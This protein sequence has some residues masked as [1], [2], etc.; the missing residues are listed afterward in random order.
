MLN[1]AILSR[2]TE[3]LEVSK[4]KGLAFEYNG[5]PAPVFYVHSLEY[6][7]RFARVVTEERRNQHEP[8]T[9]R[10]VFFFVEIET[11]DVYKAAG[12]KAPAKGVRYRL[13]DDKSFAEMKERIG[14]FSGFLYR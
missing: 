10:R 12:W 3:C 4:A 7:K 9:G 11:G 13:S 14:P 6:G 5:K 1:P 2:L 8:L